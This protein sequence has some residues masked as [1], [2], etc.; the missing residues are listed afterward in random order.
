MRINCDSR[1]QPL[2]GRQLTNWVSNSAHSTLKKSLISSIIFTLFSVKYA[3]YITLFNVEWA[4]STLVALSVHCYLSFL[5]G[6]SFMAITCFSVGPFP[7]GFCKSRFCRHKNQDLRNLVSSTLSVSVVTTFIPL[8]GSIPQRLSLKT[9][10]RIFLTISTK[11][12]R[13]DEA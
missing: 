6:K 12:E 9:W 2:V 13:T 10:A 5:L 4:L 1:Q 7:R 3:K 11:I 8:P